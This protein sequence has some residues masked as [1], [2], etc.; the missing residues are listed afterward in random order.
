MEQ[1]E[2]DGGEYQK[3][4]LWCRDN[5]YYSIVSAKSGK[6]ISVPS[7]QEHSADVS[8]VQETY[9]G[10]D[11]QLW[12]ITPTDKGY[13]IIKAKSAEGASDNLVMSVGYGLPNDSDGVNIEQ[14][15][16]DEHTEDYWQH[17]DKWY[18]CSKVDF[19]MST[20]NYSG[21]GER[22][23]QSYFYGSKFWEGLENGN[24][25][26]LTHHYNKD[27]V[28]TASKLDFAENGAMSVDTDF[29]I[30]IGHGHVAHRGQDSQC[31]EQPW[32]NHVQYGYSTGGEVDLSVVCTTRD[33]AAEIAQFCL[34]TS[35]ARFGSKETD[36]RWVWMYTCNFL[37]TNEY[38]LD[39][40]LKEMMTGAHIV[41]GYGTQSLLCEPNV[42][43]FAQNLQNG[44]PII[45]AFFVAGIYGE[46]TCTM[47]NHLQR[48]L[49]IP[50]TEYETI[51]S[52]QIHYNY[53]PE[54][55]RIDEQRIQD[56]NEW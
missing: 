5:G 10:A 19:G 46:A 13:Y 48:V 3:W 51:Y 31:P 36:L 35:E 14:R 52:P 47:D 37:N 49:Y 34:Y 22:E 39:S 23:L 55:V 43:L 26:T 9:I 24:P 53:E 8:L 38:V 50:Q 56:H 21:G 29:M 45:E 33:D 4:T 40:K 54:D 27:D 32:G 12:R 18:I 1:W 28:T 17:K 11:R 25:F 16:Y 42:R 30:Y 41:M 2:Y 6:A 44:M 7:G 20:D 15:V